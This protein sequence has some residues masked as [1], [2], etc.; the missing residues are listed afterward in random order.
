MS[1]KDNVAWNVLISCYA[2][3]NRTRDALVVF[4]MM[5][6]EQCG[7]QQDDV[8]CFIV[9]QA[10]A[11]LGALE[12]GERVHNYIHEHEFGNAM[13]LCYFLIAMYSRCGCVDKA[14]QVFKGMP[15]KDVVSWSAMM[16]GIASH[17]HREEA[18][19]AFW[20]MQSMGVAP[21]DQTFTGVLSACS[22][23]GLVFSRPIQMLQAETNGDILIKSESGWP[24][25]PSAPRIATLKDDSN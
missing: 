3:N 21:D 25:P 22:H 1:Q 14:Y 5:E 19:E 12:F 8:T 15:S 20:E 17:G 2:R 23:S 6:S 18:I 16:S 7:S 24:I 9:L 13:N 10:C 11:N 4:D